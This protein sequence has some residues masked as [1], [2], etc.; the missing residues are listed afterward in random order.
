M[1]FVNGRQILGMQ[2]R[3]VFG[4][5]LGAMNHTIIVKGTSRSSRMFDRGLADAGEAK[6]FTFLKQ[7]K[8]SR[9]RDGT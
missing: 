8:S 3:F 7:T 5:T 1:S 9:L 2:H 4:A 6:S